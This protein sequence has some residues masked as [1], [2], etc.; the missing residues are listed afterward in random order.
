MRF[1]FVFI[2]IVSF[3]VLSLSGPA[4]S[5]WFTASEFGYAFLDDAGQAFVD[6]RVKLSQ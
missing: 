6:G 4:F 5:Y 3:V 1:R 2:L